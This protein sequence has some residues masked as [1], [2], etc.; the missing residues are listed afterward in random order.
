MRAIHSIFHGL[1]AL[2]VLTATSLYGQNAV[3][4]DPKAAAAAAAAAAAPPAFQDLMVDAKG[5]TVGRL[6]LQLGGANGGGVFNPVSVIY[7]VRQISGIW[8]L[9]QIANADLAGGFQTALHSSD[10]LYLYQSI[11]C[12][13]QAYLGVNNPNFPGTVVTGPAVGFVT[14]IPP[15]TAP[16]IYFAGP[17]AMVTINSARNVGGSCAGWGGTPDPVYV[18]PA[19]SMPVSSLGLTL[20]FS[21]K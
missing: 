14:A 5:K 8:V 1:V 9:L 13:G 11:D 4:L 17:P 18:G 15:A 6:F 19:Q 20:P 7:V 2:G 21:I 12:T 16:S 10:L 3:V